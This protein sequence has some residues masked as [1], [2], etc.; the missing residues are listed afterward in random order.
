[1]RALWEIWNAVELKELRN[2]VE[3]K[4]IRIKRL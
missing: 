3:L 1:V 4:E 2:G